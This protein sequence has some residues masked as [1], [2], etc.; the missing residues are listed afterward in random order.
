MK[1]IRIFGDIR[2][3]SSL[4]RRFA[5]RAVA[6]NPTPFLRA[7]FTPPRCHA[8]L[9]AS[10][11]IVAS[12]A[13]TAVHAR[14]I[15][16]NKE[17]LTNPGPRNADL[18]NSGAKASVINTTSG[19]WTG[20]V[21]SNTNGAKII[22]QGKWTGEIKSNASGAITNQGTWTGKATNTGGTIDNK[23]GTWTGNIN[24]KSGT[25][26][27][28]GS[29]VG[30]MTN[31]E[32][33]TNSGSFKGDVAN[34]GAKAS[35]TN[36]KSGA[37]T[38]DVLSNTN[39]AKIIN[40]GKWTGEVKS[41]AS[42]TITN[43]GTWTGKA[44]NT[45]GT[46]DNKGGT[47]TGNINNKSG[48]FT[49]SGSVVGQLV[50]NG[51]VTNSGSFKG[52]VE[53]SGAK[54]SVT[55]M[56]S[57]AWTGD[58]LSNT[59]GAKIVNQG[60]WT[61][62][63]KSNASGAI[64]NQGTWTGNATN[65]GGTIDNKGGTWNGNINNKSGTFTNSGGVVSGLL[66]NGG[67]NSINSGLIKGGVNVTGG[68]VSSS[69]T[70]ERGATV[71]G[72]RL[73]TTGV[74]NGGVTTSGK[75]VVD[76]SGVIGGLIQNQARFNVTGNLKSDA[77]VNGTTGTLEVQ[78][79][80]FTG[81]TTDLTVSNGGI[82]NV[83]GGAT[84]D[85]RG[86]VT[87]AATGVITVA[88]GG[89]VNDLLNNKGTVTN[90]GVYN[91]DVVNSGAKALITN[92][93]TGSWT[94]DV[95]SNTKG[96]KITNQGSWTGDAYNASGV[97]DNQGKWTGTV[98][99]GA[100]GTFT[101]SK[102][103]SLSGLLTTAGTATNAGVLKGGALVTGGTLTTTGE[104]NTKLVNLATVKAQGKINGL[105]D[106]S[107]KLI[108][109]GSLTNNGSTVLNRTGGSI[110]VRSNS[111]TGIGTLDNAAEVT[112]GATGTLTA[113]K[114]SQ[115]T[116]SLTN[117]GKLNGTE[118]ID[119]LGGILNNEGQVTSKAIFTKSGAVV[120]N[121]NVINGDLTN[122]G[123]FNQFANA[124]L[125]GHLNNRAAGLVKAAGSI[126]GGVTNE[127]VF[128]VT[129]DLS[130]KGGEFLNKNAGTLVLSGG[131]Y[132]EIGKLTNASSAAAGILISA[133][134]TLSA[135]SVT[136]NAG[137]TIVNAGTLASTD[138]AVQNAGA[139]NTTGTL[140]ALNGGLIN[141]GTVNAAGAI[142]GGVTNM[143]S[144]ATTGALNGSGNFINGG[145]GT[146][147]VSGG[148]FKQIGN[149]TNESAALIGVS[150]LSG[151]T[152][153]ALKVRNN[154]RIDNFGTLASTSSPIQNAGTLNTTGAL[155]GG[156]QNTGIVKASGSIAGG[157]ANKGSFTVTGTLGS[158]GGKFDNGG[159]L[160]VSG[161]D[162]TNIATLTN[163]SIVTIAAGRQLGAAAVDNTGRIDLGS[164]VITG[165]VANNGVLTSINGR[166]SGNLSNTG[167][168]D[169]TQPADPTL[170][171]PDR[172]MQCK[173][174][175]ALTNTL[176]VS[177]TYAGGGALSVVA[178]FADLGG[179]RAGELLVGGAGSGET[180]VRV[181][182]N[183]QVGYFGNPILIASTREG[184]TSTF[185]LANAAALN[186]GLA[187]FSLQ[188]LQPGQWYLVP[189]LDTGSLS[190]VGGSIASAITSA[191]TG[192][193]QNA[194]G[195]VPSPPDPKP[196]TV[197]LGLWSR[198]AVGRADL[199]S[200]STAP[201]AAGT[202]AVTHEKTR[203]LYNGYQVGFDAALSNYENTQIS[204]HA[205][206]TAGQYFSNSY[207]MMGSGTKT[208]IDVPFVGVY[209]VA[210]G[211]GFFADVQFR[212]DFWN[213]HVTNYRAD[214]YDRGLLGRGWAGSASVG[215]RWDLPDNWFIE[216][217]A[218]INITSVDF[219]R[220]AVA[221]G[222]APAFLSIGT[223]RST[224]GR[225][226]LRVG[227]SFVVDKYAFQ[228]FVTISG[229]NEF[230][231]NI[232]QVFQQNTTVVPIDV[233]RAGAFAQFGLGLSAQ[234]IDTGWISFVRGDYR[235]GEK[236]SG[237][238]LNGGVVY[239]F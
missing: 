8:L 181:T 209:G 113:N 197:S 63:V 146:L 185:T 100:A 4:S 170:C 228:P 53:N 43:Q 239:R 192:F 199:S 196:N 5:H 86:G 27:N 235:T 163:S 62:E 198:A 225:V 205:G 91:G 183:G 58:V 24:N 21:L 46:I 22:N 120:N 14:P 26:T 109:T 56:K 83:A 36:T 70:I 54:A 10:T 19:V 103:G 90:S 159:E 161:G 127:G 105:I 97:I 75:G 175:Q 3:S 206:V 82:L 87:N 227:T 59:N 44:T 136:N 220:L 84:L 114:I 165:N 40:Q 162:Y 128:T 126:S 30:Q 137:S 212:H 140:K 160:N 71:S 204:F 219:D 125:N 232:K 29:V 123:S 186:R 108:V 78:K 81:N 118:R 214:L 131:D 226:G 48:T 229:W 15:L 164:G 156:L 233:S 202:N 95:L 155:S 73:S 77:V 6:S 20:D 166:I 110:S 96:A 134:R 211:Y 94:G 2:M 72:G 230:E 76:A 143:G 194:S 169:L 144:F 149:L 177:G 237:A 80:V 180:E 157:V 37:W 11:A 187:S 135:N 222:S 65:T 47:W 74:I 176:N 141:T 173:L 139:L 122:E 35:I 168:I 210:T 25:F 119:I 150:I 64:T 216:P 89:K 172:L 79:G 179:Q 133:N 106:N 23:G 107:G 217:S 215:Y 1:K 51:Q 17:K 49:N 238:A 111:F 32:K 203:T 148:D 39:G 195:L 98:N 60:K 218:A 16:N 104:I 38:G 236:L 151:R 208:R 132:T 152:L 213:A 101:N 57:G 167:L 12:L 9:L 33:V 88:Q 130:N 191:A 124:S 147:L 188:E 67:G 184:S 231:G 189:N 18:N 7:S 121:R 153:S 42:G 93:K 92:T 142:Q 193:F 116:G 55:N 221:A 138:G 223:V 154:A 13:G 190:A 224:L 45:G 31:N 102:S 145:A 28:S 207:E 41:N 171:A 52:D 112:V 61:G 234:I 117:A 201:T 34:S 129:G 66:T 158:G 115:T 178:K 85:A 99:N 174:D 182:P 68:A 69:G 50:N 200:S